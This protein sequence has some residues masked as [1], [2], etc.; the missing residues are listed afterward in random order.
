M[1]QIVINFGAPRSGTHFME[2]VCRESAYRYVFPVKLEEG[3]IFH[4]CRSRDGMLELARWFR[5]SKPLFIRTVRH[6]LELVESFLALR[7]RGTFDGYA[8]VLAS[9][10]DER[11]CQFINNE[12]RN[13]ARQR[14]QMRSPD[15]EHTGQKYVEVRMDELASEGVKLDLARR[16]GSWLDP[17]KCKRFLDDYGRVPT[18]RGRLSEGMLGESRMT[19]HQRAFFEERLAE[20]IQR[21]GYA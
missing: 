12:S 2:M 10:T 6:P 17:H 5:L 15:W 13:T 11:I 21:E 19:I 16:L 1:N 18:T 4:P 9:F 3:R 20:T 7:D 8:G 14:D